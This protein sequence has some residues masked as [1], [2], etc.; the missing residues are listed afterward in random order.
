MRTAVLN[1]HVSL[2]YSESICESYF[3]V[4]A[5]VAVFFDSEQSEKISSCVQ[6]SQ[7]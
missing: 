1:C 7:G 2:E 6:A 4:L 5:A 3:E